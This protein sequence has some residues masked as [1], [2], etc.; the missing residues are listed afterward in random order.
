MR[1]RDTGGAVRAAAVAGSWYPGDALALRA[2]IES[3]LAAAPLDDAGAAP[4]PCALVAPHAGLR[5]SGATAAHAFARLPPGVQRVVVLA[6]SH[7]TPLRGAAVDSSSGYATPLGV[8]PV[9]VDAVAL[10]AGAGCVGTRD[11][12]VLE[13]A[14]EMQL[15]FLQ[16]CAP[17]AR[18]VPVLVGERPPDGGAALAAAV[19]TLLD[20][21]TVVVV[22]SDF[23]HYGSRYGWVPFTADV[24]A[25]IRAVDSAAVDALCRL[26]AAGFDAMLRR[27][28]ATICGR[29]PLALLLRVL[30]AGTEGTLLHYDTSG[31]MTGDWEH[32]VSYAALAFANAAL[33]VLPA[34]GEASLA[35]RDR[36]RLLACA[37]HALEALFAP[38]SLA[39]RL[40]A[41]LAPAL[42]PRGVFVSLHR[43]R[44]GRLRGCIGSLVA[45]GSLVDAVAHN[46][47]RAA[48]DDPRFDPV[49]ADEL[50]GLEIEIS[51]LSPLQDVADPEEIV[52][53]RH[54]V[55]VTLGL[56]R[57]V[58]L[59]HV[60]TH[61]NWT[62]A[63]LLDNVCDKAGLPRDAWRR[64]AKLQRFEAERFAE[65]QG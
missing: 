47:Q 52:V 37:R 21:R 35:A 43:R 7:R 17:D 26:D 34:S 13:H 45:A 38:P 56:Q 46:A 24:P 16:V 27:T 20:G 59:P 63:E 33:R 62:H 23:V 12:F 53:G 14:I 32:S 51:V 64:G 2:E 60:A 22:S 11:P 50:A 55:V 31:A 6:P 48:T 39:A 10:L 8:V 5:Y 58:L 42:A 30:P 36:D 18:L 25:R 49:R 65:P 3:L 9:D 44:D 1:G 54:G 41:L 40:E 61:F 29:N 57:G 4:S 28:G 19:Q 15:P